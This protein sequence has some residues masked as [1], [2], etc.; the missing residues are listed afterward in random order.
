[1]KAKSK[2]KAKLTK[3]INPCRESKEAYKKFSSDVKAGHK[4]AEGYWLGQSEAYGTMCNQQSLKKKT[5]RK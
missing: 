3:A 4:D 1:M 5:K 2:S